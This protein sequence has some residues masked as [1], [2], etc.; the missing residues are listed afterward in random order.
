[1]MRNTLHKT[2]AVHWAAFVLFV[3]T[4]SSMASVAAGETPNFVNVV[5]KG[6]PFPIHQ[7]IWLMLFGLSIASFSM[8]I[9]SLVK[10]K[11]EKLLPA[12]VVDGVRTCL[13]EGD[14]EGAIATCEE[15]P[16]QLSNILLAGFSQITEG[17]DV[18][19]ET[20]TKA[21][22]M[23]TEKI[24]QRLNFLNVFGQMGPMLGLMG[25]VTGMISAFSN[26]GTT[27][28]AGKASALAVS[29]AGALWATSC[30]LLISIPS[31]LGYTI[32]RNQAIKIIIETE[33]TVI[34]LIK[35]L[36]K[37][38]VTSDAQE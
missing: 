28:G 32:L 38:E 9:D 3:F 12:H 21:S 14:L 1:M 23:E 37:A 18:I 13:Q 25:T 20:I 36:R 11:R 7:I 27:T 6:D 10:I 24:L 5:I 16:G 33:Q 15:N 34:D 26:L 22:E 31:L 4:L 17:F 19:Q 35:T 30:G 8:I 2:K 29:I